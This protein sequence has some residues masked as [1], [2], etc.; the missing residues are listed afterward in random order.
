MRFTNALVAAAS[1]AYVAEANASLTSVLNVANADF[2]KT[3]QF[4]QKVFLNMQ[5]DT[6]NSA[7]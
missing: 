1:V 6:T 2:A 5:R 4:W 3:T 7:S